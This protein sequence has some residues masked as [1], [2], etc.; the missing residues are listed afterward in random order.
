MTKK[1]GKPAVQDAKLKAMGAPPEFKIPRGETGFVVTKTHKNSIWTL[2]SAKN[3]DEA[4]VKVGQ[5][6]GVRL[7]ARGYFALT[8]HVGAL[9]VE[10]KPQ[11]RAKKS[12]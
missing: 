7:P 4:L 11:A 3:A 8:A 6:L 5:G 10:K 9:L 12:R 1:N 2:I